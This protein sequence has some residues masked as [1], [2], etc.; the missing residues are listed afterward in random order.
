MRLVA[1]IAGLLAVAVLG[2]T[3]THADD[4]ILGLPKQAIGARGALVIV[5]GGSTTEPIRDEF[6]RLAGGPNARIVLIPSAC[7]SCSR[8]HIQECLSVWQRFPLASL[9]FLDAG[10]RE[11]ADSAEFVAPLEQATGVW[12]PGGDQGRLIEL[13]GGTRVE[14]AIRD[15]LKRG[16]VVGGTSA[17]AAVMSRIMI[18]EG[19]T[20]EAVVG[21]GF[22]LLEGAVVDQHFSQRGRHA[23]LLQVLDKYPGML[24]L[25]VDESTALIVEGNRLR[26]L[27]KSHVTVCV[28][29]SSRRTTLIYRFTP[30]EE[31]EL[32]LAAPADEKLPIRVARKKDAG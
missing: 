5:G 28:P 9:E 30:G 2:M 14:Q 22:G 20:C 6:V 1:G 10:C 13:Y 16:G 26:V 3:P 31:I 17:G 12:M 25:G 4:N 18:L 19:T 8:E 11:Q 7:G 21:Q 32:T 24:G 29:A 27:G 23:R 15:V